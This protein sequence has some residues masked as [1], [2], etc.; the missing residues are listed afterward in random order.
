MKAQFRR[1]L[2]GMSIAARQA[3]IMSFFLHDIE[4]ALIRMKA[5]IFCESDVFYQTDIKIASRK[6]N[7]FIRTCEVE[8][9]LIANIPT[10]RIKIR[11]SQN[12]RLLV[13]VCEAENVCYRF[14][15]NNLKPT[16]ITL[17]NFCIV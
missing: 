14:I 13:G 16:A 17:I 5:F 10:I 15:E 7:P 11:L 3:F 9:K 4:L 6:S 1:Q 12:I 8:Y 2:F